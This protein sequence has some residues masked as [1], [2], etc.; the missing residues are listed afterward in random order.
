M[1]VACGDDASPADEAGTGDEGLTTVRLAS[2]PLGHLAP[3][4]IAQERGIFAEH[5]L[6]VEVDTESSDLTSVPSVLA[7]R[8]D[9]ATGDLT[10]LIVARSKGL[11]VKAVVPASASTGVPG[12]DYGALVVAGDSGITRP[13]QLEGRTVSVNI[14]TNIAAAAA[15]EAVTADGGDAD[16]VD[17]VELPFPQVPAAISTGQVDGAWV[18][19]PFLSAAKAEGAVPIGWG[20]TDL[21]EDLTVSSWYTSG[22]YAEQNPETVEAF[23]DAVREA[24]AYAREHEDEVRE[25]IPTF[26]EI[27]PEVA[28][29]ITITGWRDEV[30]REAAEKL[31]GYAL[32]DG[33]ITEEPDLDELILP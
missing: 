7:D 13:S 31:V 16:A 32:R 24:Y 3:I 5:G 4:R 12:E 17:L 23:R 11:D 25:I 10:T 9:F 15:R 22:S 33:L 2:A 29:S 14:L 21:A 19:E 28:A 27:S 8:V 6:D 18:V 30:S 26:T 20:F 1:L